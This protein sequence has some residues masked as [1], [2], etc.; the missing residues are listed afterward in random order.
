MRSIDDFSVFG[1]NSTSSTVESLAAGGV[2]QIAA[3]HLQRRHQV[4]ALGPEVL[5]VSM[6]L[7]F[8]RTTLVSMLV[9]GRSYK[10]LA[11]SLAFKSFMVEAVWHPIKRRVVYCR[12]LA[13][14][15]GARNSVY[16]VAGSGKAFQMLCSTLC[17]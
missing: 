4:L 5:G 14:L 1:Q 7:R 3:R 6:S 15:F 10:N 9:V 8:A 13:M 12:L 17:R 11:P 16:S 2:D